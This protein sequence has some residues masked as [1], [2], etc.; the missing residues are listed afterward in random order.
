MIKT[1]II[2]IIQISSVIGTEDLNDIGRDIPCI[3]TE[4]K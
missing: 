3:Q 4:Q 1:I 2:I